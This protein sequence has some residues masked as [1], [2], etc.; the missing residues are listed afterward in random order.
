MGHTLLVFGWRPLEKYVIFGVFY[1]N[2]RTVAPVSTRQ[3]PLGITFDFECN[4]MVFEK[5]KSSG[6]KIRD[7][8]SKPLPGR[9]ISQ[10]NLKEHLRISLVT[11]LNQE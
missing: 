9:T 4:E 10:R 1:N 11:W 5:E 7:E 3:A 8:F 6:R 2:I